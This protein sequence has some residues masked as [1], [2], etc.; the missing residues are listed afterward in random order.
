MFAIS[1]LQN[2]TKW[3]RKR[4]ET[5]LSI[6]QLDVAHPVR[7]D[8]PTLRCESNALECTLYMNRWAFR[9]T[10]GGQ[11]QQQQRERIYNII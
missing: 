9:L 8:P 4:P 7:F 6:I 5:L 11:Q 10:R 1:H 3:E 2:A